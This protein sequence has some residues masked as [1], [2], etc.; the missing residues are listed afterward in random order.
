MIK[1]YDVD[2]KKFKGE[3]PKLDD[4]LNNEEKNNVRTSQV[5]LRRFF[6]L[7]SSLKIHFML[8]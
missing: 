2:I 1:N 7:L 4:K 6:V 5:C 8:L 3:E